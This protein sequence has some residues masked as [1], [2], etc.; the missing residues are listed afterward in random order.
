MSEKLRKCR[1]VLNAAAGLSFKKGGATMFC[2]N[3]IYWTVIVPIVAY[4]SQ[5]WTVKQTDRDTLH[6]FQVLYKRIYYI[7]K[8]YLAGKV[9]CMVGLIR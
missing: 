1:K 7:G 5:L 8:K 3:L 6:G 2:C 9:S 4:G